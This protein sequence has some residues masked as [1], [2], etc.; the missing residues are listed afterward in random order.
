[1]VDRVLVTDTLPEEVWLPD[2]EAEELRVPLSVGL[3][4]TLPVLQPETETVCE[5]VTDGL[6]LKEGDGLADTVR[7]LD[8]VLH[9]VGLVV[10]EE[11]VEPDTDSVLVM[12]P[13]D[14]E[15]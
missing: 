10:T 3:R 13:E 7:V 2:T 12:V 9:T 4:V 1:M 15:D 14:E 8:T 6:E 11:D 5:T